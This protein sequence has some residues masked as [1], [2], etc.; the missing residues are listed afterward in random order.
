MI[1]S[2]R[3]NELSGRGNVQVGVACSFGAWLMSS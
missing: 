1:K 2:R 3:G